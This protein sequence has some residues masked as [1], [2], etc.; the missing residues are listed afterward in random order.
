MEYAQAVVDDLDFTIDE[1]VFL[2]PGDGETAPKIE[3]WTTIGTTCW[4]CSDCT[5]CTSCPCTQVCPSV[6]NC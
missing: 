5:D 6:C 3:M 2:S 4:S 1:E